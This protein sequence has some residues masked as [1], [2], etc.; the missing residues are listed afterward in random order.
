MTNLE[1]TE[2]NWHWVLLFWYGAEFASD[3]FDG[4]DLSEGARALLV[5]EDVHVVKSLHLR[6]DVAARLDESKA[7]HNFAP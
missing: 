7:F 3:L 6:S 4:D 5:K 2:L 1:Q